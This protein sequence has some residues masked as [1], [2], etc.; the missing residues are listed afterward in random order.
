MHQIYL[1]LL[2][3]SEGL[4]FFGS[5]IFGAIAHLY[6]TKK[7]P[8]NF[9]QTAAFLV[10]S[11]FFAFMGGWGSYMFDMDPK[12][13][14]ATAMVCGFCGNRAVL[15]FI[16]VAFPKSGIKPDSIFCTTKALSDVFNDTTEPI[17]QTAKGLLDW[18]YKEERIDKQEYAALLL[19][20][21]HILGVLRLYRRLTQ[22]EHD[23][24]LTSDLF[25][26]DTGGVKCP[27]K[28]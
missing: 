20:D 16:A 8:K 19:G 21:L 25:V 23:T 6:S 26:R 2:D 22:K 9:K 15:F 17:D 7:F 14:F 12:L 24:L 13:R 1:F 4:V 10:Y 18:L 11:V 28:I 5:G 27:L 3:C